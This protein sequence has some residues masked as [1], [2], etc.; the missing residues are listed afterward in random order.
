MD[1]LHGLGLRGRSMSET[2][3]K[4]W[5][6]GLTVEEKQEY[7]DLVEHGQQTR[8]WGP[9][10]AYFVGRVGDRT[11]EASTEGRHRDRA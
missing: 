7:D 10:Y 9:A 8:D 6:A 3:V 5:W 1:Q 2:E 11:E 4:R